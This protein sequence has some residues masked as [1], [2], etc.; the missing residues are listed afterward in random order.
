MRKRRKRRGSL[1]LLRYRSVCVTS[2][3]V[4]LGGPYQFAGPCA[5]L[6]EL[7]ENLLSPVDDST[8]WATI[9]FVPAVLIG[10]KPKAPERRGRVRRP[11]RELAPAN[12]PRLRRQPRGGHAFELEAFDGPAVQA[13][14]LRY[15]FG[16]TAGETAELLKTSKATPCASP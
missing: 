10:A 1:Q 11:R 6:W 2:N 14:E 13:L 15:I 8:V 9:R 12:R 5:T 16:F 3:L 4:R 7:S